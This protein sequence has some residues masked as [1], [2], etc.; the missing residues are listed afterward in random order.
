MFKPEK[1]LTHTRTFKLPHGFTVSFR[2]GADGIGAEW[3][4]FM[5]TK[6]SFQSLKAARRL[7]DAYVDARTDFLTDL[8]TLNGINVLVID[9]DEFTVVKPGV[10][11]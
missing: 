1:A 3:T 5:P 4:P 9:P 7:F 6:R 10:R 2:L 8:A 11:Q